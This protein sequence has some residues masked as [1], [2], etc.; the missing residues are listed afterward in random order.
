M[1]DPSQT[2]VVIP[3]YNEAPAIGQV[4]AGLCPLGYQV[5][6]VDDGSVDSTREIALQYPI[7][8]LQHT[9]N[10]G[11]GAALQ[12]GITYA[13]QNPAVQVIVTFDSDGQHNPASI[14]DLEAVLE[15]GFDVALGSRFMP[16]GQAQNI[17]WLKKIVLRLAIQITR[18]MTGLH[19]T[20][21][22]NGLRAFKRSAAAKIRI[23]QNGMAHASEILSQV[24]LLGLRYC[25]VPVDIHYTAYSL[26]K[27]Q[28][29]L[30]GV[31]ILWDIL[32]GKIR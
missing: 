14:A 7:T 12:T 16:G 32:G 30:N 29:I 13:L 17:P 31:N 27:G 25:E 24:A 4:L 9:T 20:D 28:S 22:H 8:L 23:R 10:L 15:R 2:A 5:I 11:Q 19:L 21:T 3:A 26:H 6:V 18:R 1:S